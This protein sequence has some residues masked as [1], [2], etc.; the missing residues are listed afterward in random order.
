MK[1]RV[2]IVRTLTTA[3]SAAIFT[4]TGWLMGTRALT[5]PPPQCGGIDPCDPGSYCSQQC[6][7]Y[8]VTCHKDTC[9]YGTCRPYRTYGLGCWPGGSCACICG[10]DTQIQSCGQSPCNIEC[11][12]D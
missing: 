8:G 5:M 4:A 7:F 10:F 9:I 3:M 2:L 11:I 1:R 6:W 12:P